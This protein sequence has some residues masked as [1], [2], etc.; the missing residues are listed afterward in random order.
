MFAQ[1]GG[2]L[3]DVVVLFDVG[4]GVGGKVFAVSG[5]FEQAGDGYG[6]GV[7]IVRRHEQAGFAVVDEFGDADDVGRDAWGTK[8]HG[9]D[10]DGWQAVAV[11][12][13][14]DDA[15]GDEHGGVMQVG[16]D[17]GLGAVADEMDLVVKAEGGDLGGEFAAFAALADDGAFAGDAV[18]AQADN[19]VDEV[20]E[21]FF[22][23]EAA[24][25]ENVRRAVARDLVGELVEVKAV[26]DAVDGGAAVVFG[27]QVGEVVVAHGD[28]EGGVLDFGG[29]VYGFGV[30]VVDVFGVSGEAV[31]D[32]GEVAG[33]AGDGRR[34]GAE[35]GVQVG[36]AVFARGEGEGDGL[37][38]GGSV[39]FFAEGEFGVEVGQL[40]VG[41]A[42]VLPVEQGVVVLV[43]DAVHGCAHAGDGFLEVGFLDGAQGVDADFRA[44][45]FVGEDFVN[46][47]GFGEARVAF[48]D[49]ADGHGVSLWV[50]VMAACTRLARP[51]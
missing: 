14:A 51:W 8:R 9:F 16:F 48:E 49:V 6:E 33:E 42:Q 20:V 17:F 47:E 15:G 22:F 25:G 35:V 21:A 36:D 4:A 18:T 37:A 29:E 23:D 44:G 50:R 27:A 30:V 32:G 24:D 34:L 1:F 39:V 28:G 45:F 38:D 5:F 7:R 11:A 13:G 10:E 26:V 43:A 31:R 19:G 40:G 12:V 41:F 2:V 3:V 46:D